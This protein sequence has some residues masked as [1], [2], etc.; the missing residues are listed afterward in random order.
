MPTGKT[1]FIL[2]EIPGPR[3][4]AIAAEAGMKVRYTTGSNCSGSEQPEVLQHVTHQDG[5]E[6]R[7]VIMRGLSMGKA[8]AIAMILNAPED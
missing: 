8:K 6:H 2:A 4:A 5:T 1:P 7:Y 3:E